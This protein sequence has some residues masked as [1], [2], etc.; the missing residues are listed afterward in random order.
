MK[1]PICDIEM[2]TADREGVEIDYCSQC[3]GVWLDR[4][5]LEKIIA[6]VESQDSSGREPNDEGEDNDRDELRD[7]PRGRDREARQ[8][9]RY[10]RDEPNKRSE[11]PSRGGKKREGFLSN[12]MEMFGGG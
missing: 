12:L 6:R 1:C 3:R 10:R 5:E 11:E 9:D 4:G 2:R 7:S 8:D